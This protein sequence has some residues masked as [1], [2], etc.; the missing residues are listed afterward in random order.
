METN[1]EV[2]QLGHLE[3]LQREQKNSVALFIESNLL[4]VKLPPTWLK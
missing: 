1:V 2:V 3:Q 4:K